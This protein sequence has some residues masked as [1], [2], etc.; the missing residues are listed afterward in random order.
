M[1]QKG[2]KRIVT[3][4]TKGRGRGGHGQQGNFSTKSREMTETEKGVRG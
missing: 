3:L 2:E 4:E 1:S